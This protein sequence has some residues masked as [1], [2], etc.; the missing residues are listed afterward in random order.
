MTLLW[1]QLAPARLWCPHWS[2]ELHGLLGLPRE[3][4]WGAER[5]GWLP[6]PQCR[7][8]GTRS[9]ESG[10]LL[11]QLLSG[12]SPF[13]ARQGTCCGYAGLGED[14]LDQG[15]SWLE[16]RRRWR[17]DSEGPASRFATELM[18]SSWEAGPWWPWGTLSVSWKGSLLGCRREQHTESPVPA[19]WGRWGGPARSSA[20]HGGAHRL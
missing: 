10:S 17:S 2:R 11:G 1:L 6:P 19:G 18:G 12:Q 8:C 5:M 9:Q 15:A 20:L 16:K 7:A 3:G 4:L 13:R 14:C